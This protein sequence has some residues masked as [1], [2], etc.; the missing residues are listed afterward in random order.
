MAGDAAGKNVGTSESRC[1]TAKEIMARLQAARDCHCGLGQDCCHWEE[2]TPEGRADCSRD[3]R[4]IVDALWK[5]GI[6][7]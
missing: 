5:N 2:L 3:K 7:V 1:P 6:A 4:A